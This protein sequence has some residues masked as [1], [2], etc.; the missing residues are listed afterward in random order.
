[1]TAAT[2]VSLG[3]ETKTCLNCSECQFVRVIPAKGHTP[4]G[5][6]IDND[7]G[8]RFKECTVCSSL[9]EAEKLDSCTHRFVSEVTDPTCTA[10]GFEIKTCADCGETR[11]VRVIAAK[12]HALKTTV[13]PATQ[14]ESGLSITSCKTCGTITKATL[15]KRVASVALSKT[16]FTYNGKVQTPTVIVKD[17]SGKVLKRNTDYTVS[18]AAGRKNPGQYSVKVTFKG[19]Y[20]G[21]KTLTFTIAPGTP[22]LTATAG[23][24]KAALKWNKQTGATGYVV[25]MATSKSGK[26]TKAATLKG[27]SKVSYT[28]TGLTKGKT[29][30]FKVCAYTTVGGKTVYGAASAVKAVKVK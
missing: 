11:F 19:D 30:Y 6:K 23:T 14:N 13:T 21:T 27:N 22:T 26:Y 3:F 28:K 1:M 18:Y 20:S 8:I 10:N 9:L 17:S 4:S 7:K 29:Y 24:K 5:W 25:Y 2:C 12:G 15:I 16:A